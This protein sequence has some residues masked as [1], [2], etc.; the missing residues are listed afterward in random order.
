MR[1]FTFLAPAILGVIVVACGGAKSNDLFGQTPPSSDA[2]DASIG[3]DGAPS[4]NGDDDD[5]DASQGA[6]TSVGGGNEGDA[7]IG[8]DAGGGGEKDSSTG[9]PDTAPPIDAAPP[10]TGVHCGTDSND[11]PEYCAD[12]E[13]CCVT[14]AASNLTFKC[15]GSIGTFP[16][17]GVPL[18]CASSN[19]CP[20]NQFC[21][22]TYFNNRYQSVRCSASPQ[23]GERN[24]STY[25][26]CDP[27]NDVDEC[28][29]LNLDCRP[30]SSLPGYYIC[31]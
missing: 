29:P 30:S 18:E 17:T 15:T 10:P 20:N 26:F 5:V 14:G 11:D 19:D 16:C 13:T 3:A 1:S 27:F 8:V 31:S 21:C 23:C 2:P 7:S 24:S 9:G 12:G 22:G 6:D 28:G 25:R 4:D